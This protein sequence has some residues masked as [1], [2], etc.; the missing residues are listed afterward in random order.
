MD[1]QTALQGE[2]RDLMEKNPLDVVIMRHVHD[3]EG[4]VAAG[5]SEQLTEKIVSCSDDG[6]A[7]EPSGA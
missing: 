4:G 6:R 1:T 3:D 7:R 5:I 2:L